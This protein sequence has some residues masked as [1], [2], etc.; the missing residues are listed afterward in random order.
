MN[1]IT[2]PSVDSTNNYAQQLLE[3]GLAPE[4]TVILAL[5][6]TSGRGQRGRSWESEPVMGLYFSLILR[7]PATHAHRQFML[8]KGI[9]VGVAD[10]IAEQT[11]EDVHIKW[12]NDILINGKKV[13]GLLIE[14]TLRGSQLSAVIV[15]VGVNL[16]QSSF[17]SEFGTEATSLKIVSGKKYAPVEE[18]SSLYR[19]IWNQYQQFLAGEDER[20]DAQYM[21]LM[22]KR[23]EIAEFVQ[24][25]QIFEAIFKKVDQEGAAVLEKDGLMIT[26]THPQVRFLM[27]NK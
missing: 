14:N 1:L 7:P 26:V 15:G 16:N 12:P 10:Y 8:N 2:L 25:E 17:S 9:A 11:D 22:Y 5:E 3:S 19:K 27:R 21:H 13:A 24:G 6:Q 18:A 20:I 4:S 23:D